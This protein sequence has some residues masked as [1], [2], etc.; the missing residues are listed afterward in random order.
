MKTSYKQHFAGTVEAQ[1][2]DLEEYAVNSYSSLLW[3]LEKE[4]LGSLLRELR[5]THKRLE[6]LDFAAGTGRIAA[7]LENFVDKSTAIEISQSMAARASRRLCAT[8][9]LCRDITARGAAIEGKYD[10]ITAFRFFLN[11]EPDLRVAAVRAL[12]A[13]L[14]N[15]SSLLVFNNHGNLWSLKILAWPHHHMRSAQKGWQPQGNYLRHSQIKH[16]LGSA[17]LRIVKVI[18]LGVLGGKIA[19]KIPF[20][21]SLRLE[22]WFSASP[23]CSKFGQDQI[24]VVSLDRKLCGGATSSTKV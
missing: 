9:V 16:L 11:A 19:A 22:R 18:G 24:Y 23:F 7:S 14:R 5:R 4:E 2:Y 15:E 8:Q 3:N 6:Y 1:N 10:L 20:E 17:G 13:R 21:R 12:A